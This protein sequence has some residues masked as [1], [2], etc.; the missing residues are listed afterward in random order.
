MDALSR[1]GPLTLPQR[2][3]SCP[4]AASPRRVC[5]DASL[6]GSGSRVRVRLPAYTGL[7]EK[8]MTREPDTDG[9]VAQ[10][11]VSVDAEFVGVMVAVGFASVAAVLALT[12]STWEIALISGLP[13]LAYMIA[14]HPRSR[15]VDTAA[16]PEGDA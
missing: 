5:P 4:G 9:G 14:L 3:G 11:M 6:A 12:F 15:F 16:G 13:V 1:D 7:S 10:N 2:P 8:P